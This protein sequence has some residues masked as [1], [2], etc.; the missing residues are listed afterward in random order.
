MSENQTPRGE[1]DLRDTHPGQIPGR[2]LALFDAG[3]LGGSPM[4]L[5]P[6]FYR[7]NVAGQT[8]AELY[9]LAIEVAAYV[10]MTR[11]VVGGRSNV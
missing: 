8:R 6:D 2:V 5:L 10:R 4:V 9:L 3:D 1:I 11:L 7:I